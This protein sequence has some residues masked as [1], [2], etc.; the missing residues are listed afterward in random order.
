M[1][2]FV[3]VIL[4]INFITGLWIFAIA[5]ALHEIEEWNILRW[6]RENYVDLPPSTN[7]S[8]RVWIVFVILMGFIW[9]AA[10]VLPGN[11]AL[12]A[13][14]FLPAI[15]IAIQNALQHVYWLFYF[16]KYAPGVISAVLMLI[17]MGVYLIARAVLL[18]LVP[19]WYVG[20][21]VL[22]VTPGLIE[23]VRAG[24]QMTKQI[25]SIHCLGIKLSEWF[26]R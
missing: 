20:I 4:Q 18:N 11:P 23:T 7:R 14:I 8:I 1:D 15:F 16:R 9:C 24:K 10:A 17:P 6:Y 21:L 25:R 19:L 12:A 5:F 13:A 22:L 3:S 2:K 26:V